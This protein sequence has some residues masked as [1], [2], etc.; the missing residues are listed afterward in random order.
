MCT[1]CFMHITELYFILDLDA[2]ALNF[3]QT[4]ESTLLVV[5]DLIFWMS[6]SQITFVLKSI[7]IFILLTTSV[8]AIWTKLKMPG[9]L[10]THSNSFGQMAHMH[11]GSHSVHLDAKRQFL[12]LHLV[13]SLKF[14]N[15]D[16]N[17][18]YSSCSEWVV[19][20]PTTIVHPFKSY[21]IF[22]K[23]ISDQAFQV[24]TLILCVLLRCIIVYGFAQTF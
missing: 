23:I 21:L 9:T 18:S 12:P 24:L 5:S 20:L 22:L 10:I 1:S 3:W 2:F 4:L 14:I 15:I 6:A 17:G 13:L 7:I 19:Y 8:R 11:S 16:R